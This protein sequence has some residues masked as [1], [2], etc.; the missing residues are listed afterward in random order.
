MGMR[1]SL[2]IFSYFGNT[3]WDYTL[4]ILIFLFS[5]A[6]LRLFKIIFL[7][8]LKKLA[9]KTK[10]DAD[11]V[12]ID[13]VSSIKPPLYL[14]VSFYFGYQLLD[15]AEKIDG[16]VY[17]VIFL[18]VVYEVVNSFARLMDY[19]IDRQAR[20]QESEANKRQTRSMMGILKLFIIAGLWVVA[21]ILILSNYGVNVSSI[22]ASLGIGGLAVALALQNILTDMFSSFSIFIDKPFQVGDYIVIGA[23]SGTVERIGLKTTR[24]K[25]LQ[26]EELVISNKELTSARLQNY[27]KM[28][29]RRVVFNLGVVYGLPVTKL[30]SIPKIVKDVVKS[31]AGAKFDRCH[32]KTFGDFSLNFEVVYYVESGEYKEYMDL[33]QKINFDIYRAFEK[34]GIDFAYP[35]QTVYVGK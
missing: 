34:E 1:E 30:R 7:S 32:F 18:L 29:K 5:L 3:L 10:T 17:F 6:I 4:A 35:T 13:I 25:T 28:E 11:D 26:G 14:L 22:I 16:V 19:F 12:M 23:D 15:F 9:Q 2:E 24:I 8:R 33:N 21:A 20:K 31:K 27:K